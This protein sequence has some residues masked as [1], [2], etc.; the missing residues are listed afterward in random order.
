MK[1][2][3]LNLKRRKKILECMKNRKLTGFSYPYN[4]DKRVIPGKINSKFSEDYSQSRFIQV[5]EIKV[6]RSKHRDYVRKI[7]DIAKRIEKH[8][9]RKVK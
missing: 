9:G 1:T 4:K 5:G 8:T 2:R 7:T 3:R 6:V